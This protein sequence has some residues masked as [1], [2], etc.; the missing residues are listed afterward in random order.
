MEEKMV[1][2]LEST[3]EPFLA[4]PGAFLAVAGFLVAMDLDFTGLVRPSITKTPEE[5]LEPPSDS[6]GTDA[7]S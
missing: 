6:S 5:E 7:T 1:D 2:W 3:F 4:L